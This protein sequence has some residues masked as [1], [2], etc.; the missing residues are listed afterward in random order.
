ME[1]TIANSYKMLHHV[2]QGRYQGIHYCG[3][4]FGNKYPGRGYTWVLMDKQGTKNG[5]KDE[6]QIFV[7]PV[8]Y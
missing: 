4:L 3:I 1:G 7:I 2:A 5:L 6:D 8:K